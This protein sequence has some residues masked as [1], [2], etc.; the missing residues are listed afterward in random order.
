MRTYGT[1]VLS[2]RGRLLEIVS[3]RILLRSLNRGRNDHLSE[4][5]NIELINIELI[6]I[7]LINNSKT[8]PVGNEMALA[9]FSFNP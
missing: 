7:E 9:C 6:N 5:I 8:I 1:Q 4:L 2:S 3:T